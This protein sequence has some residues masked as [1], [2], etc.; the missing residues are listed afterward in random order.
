MPTSREASFKASLHAC[1][2]PLPILNPIRAMSPSRKKTTSSKSRQT[3]D[4]IL[5]ELEVTQR[6]LIEKE[7][8]LVLCQEELAHLIE[9]KQDTSLS[10]LETVSAMAEEK[11]GLLESELEKVASTIAAQE[12]ELLLLKEEKEGLSKKLEI[13]NTKQT[14]NE[15][16]KRAMVA[17]EQELKKASTKITDQEICNFLVALSRTKKNYI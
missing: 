3:K 10:E 11:I 17:L 16:A 14:E 15:A 8:E 13:S 4:V 2:I 7:E 5:K 9:E 1:S 6:L 12:E